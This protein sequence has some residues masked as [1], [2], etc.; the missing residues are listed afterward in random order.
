M[1]E[2][3]NNHHFQGQHVASGAEPPRNTAGLSFHHEQQHQSYLEAMKSEAQVRV[4]LDDLERS[5]LEE[6]MKAYQRSALLQRL[7]VLTMQNKTQHRP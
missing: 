1:D 7:G 6:S 2:Q 4:A 3:S 5:F